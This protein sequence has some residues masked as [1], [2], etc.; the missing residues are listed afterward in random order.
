MDTWTKFAIGNALADLL[1][2]VV[3]WLVHSKPGT[4]LQLAGLVGLVW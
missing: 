3:I 1:L 4:P 2:I